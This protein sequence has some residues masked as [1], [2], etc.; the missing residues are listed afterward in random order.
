M[1]KINDG[2]PAFPC[3]QHETQDGTWNQTFDPGMSLHAYI[4]T[5]ALQCLVDQWDDHAEAA[6]YAVAYAD[7]LIAELSKGAKP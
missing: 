3:E 2:G 4:A 7:A 1:S 6:K 5:M